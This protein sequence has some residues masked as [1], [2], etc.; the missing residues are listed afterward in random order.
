MEAM[1]ES[2]QSLSKLAEPVRTYPQVLKN[3]RVADKQAVTK[4]P[5]VQAKIE[6]VT[7]ELNGAGRILLRESGT[8]PVIRVM[9]EADTEALCHRYVDEVTETIRSLGLA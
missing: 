4:N 6:E 8:E 1:I 5:T 9:V 3:L 2:K 7:R